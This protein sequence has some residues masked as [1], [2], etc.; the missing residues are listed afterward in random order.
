MS[1]IAGISAGTFPY[2][3]QW[4]QQQH[5]NS[6][7]KNYT[8][9][10]KRFSDFYENEEEEKLDSSNYLLCAFSPLKEQLLQQWK[11]V[12]ESE[13]DRAGPNRKKLAELVHHKYGIAANLVENYLKNFERTLPV[14]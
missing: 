12:S 2:G 14:E 10:S 3:G 1:T 8:N 4:Y 13:V 9:G 5:K 11:L 6:V 7:S